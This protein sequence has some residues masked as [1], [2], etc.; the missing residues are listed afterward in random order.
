MISAEVEPE[1]GQVVH[2][3]S[4]VGEI[5]EFMP[6]KHIK[7]T[8]VEVQGGQKKRCKLDVKY[9]DAIVQIKATVSGIPLALSREGGT[10]HPIGGYGCNG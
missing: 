5:S 4:H 10:W 9:Q 7:A 2:Y 3:V 6:K 8:I 1:A